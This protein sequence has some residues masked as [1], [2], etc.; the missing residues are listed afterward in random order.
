M[1]P[2]D[3]TNSRNQDVEGRSQTTTSESTSDTM[4]SATIA[5]VELLESLPADRRP[6]MDTT[7]LYE[8]VDTDALNTLIENAPAATQLQVEFTVEETTV[9][10]GSDGTV[11]VK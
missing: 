10:V 5:V 3:E 2:P 11:L 4:A 6:A 1:S 7:S 8:Y 9:L